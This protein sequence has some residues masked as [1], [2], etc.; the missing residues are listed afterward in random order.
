MDLLNVVGNK[1]IL[2]VRSL[3]ADIQIRCWQIKWE[4]KYHHHSSSCTQFDTPKIKSIPLEKCPY[5]DYTKLQCEYE[6]TS[7]EAL[8]QWLL[9]S[10]FIYLVTESF[11]MTLTGSVDGKATRGTTTQW[12]NTILFLEQQTL[13]A[14]SV[15]I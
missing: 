11:M 7:W 13:H 12:L 5:L 4:T 6:D 9:C 8:H 14:A 15:S 2:C 1:A 3:K 10:Q